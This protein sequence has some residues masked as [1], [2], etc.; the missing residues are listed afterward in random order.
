M[1]SSLSR[2]RIVDGATVL[3]YSPQLAGW[4]AVGVM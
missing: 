2:S 3:P 1:I 4:L